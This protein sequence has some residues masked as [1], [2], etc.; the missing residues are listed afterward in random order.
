MTAPRPSYGT[1]RD[2]LTPDDVEGKA[3]PLTVATAELRDMAPRGSRREDNKII[4][5]FREFPEK[6]YVCNATSY[7][8]LVT[9]LG[10]D[11]TRWHGKTVI[12]AP[13]TNEFEGRSYEKLHVASLERWDKVV[14]Q[15]N[16]PA[17]AKSGRGK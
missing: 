10:D 1:M 8:T 7:K 6:E 12:M 16:A 11:Y 9:K 15:L 3:A 14:A 17:S 2:K 13:T 5:V 4:I